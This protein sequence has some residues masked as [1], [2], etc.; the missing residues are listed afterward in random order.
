MVYNFLK[1]LIKES[2]ELKLFTQKLSKIKLFQSMTEKTTLTWFLKYDGT[3][4]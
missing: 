2:L 3:I 1:E 4:L